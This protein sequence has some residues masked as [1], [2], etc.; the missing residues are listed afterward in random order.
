MATPHA[1]LRQNARNAR[2][3]KLPSRLTPEYEIDR[4]ASRCELLLLFRRFESLALALY[5]EGRRPRS[6]LL[7]G[8]LRVFLSSA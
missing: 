6:A 5:N 4:K 1:A 3:L 8:L 2:I 7:L